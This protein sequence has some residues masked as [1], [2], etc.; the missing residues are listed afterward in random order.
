MS[1]VPMAQIISTC[2]QGKP[3]L[4]LLD[5]V[6]ERLDLAA[7]GLPTPLGDRQKVIFTTRNQ[8]ICVQMG[9]GS[10]TTI[11]MKCLREDDAWNLFQDIVGKETVDAHPHIK[12]L[13]EE[14]AAECRGLPS[15][16]CALGRA[17]STK[18][19]VKEWRYAYD[20]LGRKMPT[21]SEIQEIDD[22]GYSD[23]H[24]LQDRLRD[25]FF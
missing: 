22:E 19:D 24:R 10:Y 8:A 18:R 3:F 21:V 17:M 16:L 2:L 12:H 13:A 7:V 15:A 6:R 11:Q 23:L 9:C 14:M 4:L 1:D 20:M 25:L 5:D